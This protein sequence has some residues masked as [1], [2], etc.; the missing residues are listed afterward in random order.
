MK[1]GM[2]LCFMMLV[3]A[4]SGCLEMLTP[5]QM[6]QYALQTETLVQKVETYQEATTDVVKKLADLNIIDANRVAKISHLSAEVDRVQGQVIDTAL[7][8]KN[9]E[10]TGDNV[11]DWLNTAIAANRATAPYNPYSQPID[12]VLGLAAA[13][14]AWLAAKQIKEA[15]KNAEAAAAS[16]LK[17]QAHKQGVE[18]T[19][20]EITA[21]TV[22]ET[23]AVDAALYTNIGEARASLGVT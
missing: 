19:V 23:K 4:T 8:I 18:K 1:N 6:Q 12:M 16:E 9:V 20:K 17:Y 3:L 2:T 14:A 22:S 7:A 11:Q 13:F 21:G 10:L 5:E 15:K